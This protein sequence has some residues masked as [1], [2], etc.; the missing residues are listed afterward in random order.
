MNA[1]LLPATARPDRYQLASLSTSGQQLPDLEIGVLRRLD[2][3]GIEM[4]LGLNFL[5]QFDEIHFD[6]RTFIL[7]LVT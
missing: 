7:T 3:M 4:L 6:T 1:G 5:W 2:R